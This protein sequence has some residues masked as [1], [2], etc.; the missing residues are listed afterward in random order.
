MTRGSVIVADAGGLVGGGSVYRVAMEGLPRD[1]TELLDAHA[2]NFRRLRHVV[3]DPFDAMTDKVLLTEARL[4]SNASIWRHVDREEEVTS[5]VDLT[6]FRVITLYEDDVPWVVSQ[7]RPRFSDTEVVDHDKV[8]GYRSMHLRVRLTPTDVDRYGLSRGALGLALEIQVRTVMQ[9][10][11]SVLERQYQ[12]DSDAASDDLITPFVGLA[13]QAR[14]FD[15]ELVRV[16]E[17]ARRERARGAA[18]T[19]PGVD[20]VPV[21]VETLVG[22]VIAGGTSTLYDTDMVVSRQNTRGIGEPHRKW[23]AQA[24]SMYRHLGFDDLRVLLGTLASDRGFRRWLRIHDRRAFM[25]KDSRPVRRG[26]TVVL[27]AQ[28]L[29]AQAGREALAAAFLASGVDNPSMA[30]RLYDTVQVP[31]MSDRGDCGGPL[32]RLT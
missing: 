2:E 16:R 21:D 11:W 24:A 3:L 29:A 23:I 12:Y 26:D 30:N 14:A 22:A 18:A 17:L 10:L 20:A 32:E 9:H 7:I 25:M 5:L 28:Y 27:F 13:N 15:A 8:T 4:K 6:A 19:L 31:F 1:L